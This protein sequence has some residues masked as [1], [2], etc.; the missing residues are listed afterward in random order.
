MKLHNIHSIPLHGL[1]LIAIVIMAVIT[2]C[3]TDLEP[4][5]QLYTG[6]KPIKYTDYQPCEYFTTTQEELDA[7]LATAPNGA[8]F[9]SSYYRTPFPYALW[10]YNGFHD[11]QSPAG[12]WLAKTFGNEP[13]ILSN[14]NPELRVSV[15]ENVLQ[16]HG[17]FR[18]TVDYD[19][20]YGK[21]KTTRK[22]SVARPRTAKIQYSVKPGQLFTFD[23]VTFRNFPQQTRQMHYADNSLI[24]PGDPFNVATLDAERKRLYQLFR[25]HGYYNYQESYT[26]FLADTM[27]T[28][29]KVQ[30]QVQLTDSL[31]S[32]AM[33]KWV[34]GR[35]NVNIRRSYD[36]QL[37]D[38]ITRSFARRDTTQAPR[39]SQQNPILTIHYGGQRSPIRPGVVLQDVQLRPGQLFSDDDYTESMNRMVSKGIYS[40]MGI[41]FKPRTNPDGTLVILPDSVR[42][43]VTGESRAGAGIL[44][45]TVNC[46]LDKPYDVTLQANYLGK[47]SGRMGPGA[48]LSFAKRNAFRGG[49][50][51]S[52]NLA[53]NYEFQTGG[54]QTSSNSYEV[55]GDLTLS[56]PR[57]WLPS[58]LKPKRR[59]WQTT[60]QTILSISRETINRSG[61][62][63]RHILSSE[64]TYSFQPSRQSRHQFTPLMVEYDRLAEM[65]DDYFNKIM[66]S[67]VMMSSLN[68]YF[69]TKMRYQYTYSSPA[70]Y[71][72]PIYWNISVTESSNV[73]ALGY[74]AFGKGWNTKDK[75]A[76]ETPFAQFVKLETEWKKTWRIGEYSTLVAHADAG[77]IKA[78]G[79]S[80]SAPFSEY[81]YVGGANSLRGFAARSIGPSAYHN[82][83][84]KYAYVTNVGDM[85]LVANLE[86]RP[87]LFG[88]LYGALFLDMGNIWNLSKDSKIL[89][90]DN[91]DGTTADDLTVIDDVLKGNAADGKLRASNFLEDLALNV[92]VGIRYDLDFFVLRLD[93]GFALHT[94]YS[95]RTDGYFNMPNFGKAQCL[96]FAIGYPF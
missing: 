86:Y 32:D 92:G 55:S 20:V 23:T 82:E 37:T 42:D 36:E 63:R 69:L 83:N 6:L 39:R 64:L 51:L 35:N 9:G 46:V 50:L 2:G 76:F 27:Q 12:Q 94:P 81:F 70:K 65:S 59:R 5:E 14:V 91:P 41:E 26:T 58:F 1:P 24:R 66:E 11:S 16:N 54:T 38:S 29:G 78:F 19:I 56:I 62:F 47:T 95:N 77:I 87:R 4:G 60:P 48:S 40:S 22:D 45:M 43:T 61:F 89:S 44:D 21:D 53:A 15:A 67:A 93:W 88:S 10:I 52:F 18:G 72:N 28:P 84:T 79:N 71:I 31:P 7:A 75:E 85:K 73:L 96:N 49:E 80:Q 33:L 3:A 90:V 57:L 25:N 68:D 30:M 13:V 17:Y 34:I 74:M 8:L